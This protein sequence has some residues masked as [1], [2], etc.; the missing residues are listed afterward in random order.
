M[1][2]KPL[3]LGIIRVFDR[4]NFKDINALG[5]LCTIILIVFFFISGALGV[6]NYFIIK[7]LL[8]LALAILLVYCILVMAKN[9]NHPK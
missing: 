4:V 7:V 1:N 3:L 5:L 6:L 2:L 9:K 8:F